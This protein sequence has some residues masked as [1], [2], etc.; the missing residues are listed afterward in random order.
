MPPTLLVGASRVRE[1]AI[2]RYRR[3]KG[4]LRYELNNPFPFFQSSKKNFFFTMPLLE[5]RAW[6]GG[7]RFSS[8]L[9]LRPTFSRVFS[10]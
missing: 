8:L 10:P 1:P 2:C 6:E 7:R 5:E 4:G 9:L 3:R